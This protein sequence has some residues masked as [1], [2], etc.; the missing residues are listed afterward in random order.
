MRAPPAGLR[1]LTPAPDGSLDLDENETVLFRCAASATID[2][3]EGNTAQSEPAGELF[4]TTARVAF[5]THARGFACDYRSLALHAVSR[6][7]A[8][9][10]AGGCV[11]CQIDGGADG[12]EAYDEDDPAT[13]H[14][15]FVPSEGAS[16]EDVYGAMSEGAM[17]NPDSEDEDEDEAYYEGEEDEDEDEAREAA[18]RRLDDL[19]VVED[20]VEAL[21][22]NDP[23]RF[24]DVED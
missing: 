11:Y 21:M 18:I 7:D 24:E 1:P 4:V 14:A 12:G 15:Y 16:V 9:F 6:A 20:E 19:V 22:R 17:L 10:G 13:A 3:D 5:L 2:D 23:G 8:R